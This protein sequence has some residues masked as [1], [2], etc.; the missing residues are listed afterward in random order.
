MKISPTFWIYAYFVLGIIFTYLAIYYAQ[1]DGIW[2]FW[3][4][5]N[6]ALA[7]YDFFNA[8]RMIELRKKINKMKKK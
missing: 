6:M 7:A 3:P 2:S 5:I 1:E 8:F 4:L